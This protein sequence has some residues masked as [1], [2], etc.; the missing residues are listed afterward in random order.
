M[1]GLQPHYTT[2]WRGFQFP[3]HKIGKNPLHD[4]ENPRFLLVPLFLIILKY[5]PTRC[6]ARFG[7]LR[8]ATFLLAKLT[9]NLQHPGKR[10][11][12]IHKSGCIIGATTTSC[13]N[14]ECQLHRRGG[15]KWALL[16]GFR[17][18]KWTTYWRP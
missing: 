9:K 2:L 13:Q 14:L 1:D 12:T 5:R 16:R 17:G 4:Y 7:R 10:G 8:A 3:P 6:A 15:Q 11:L 18:L